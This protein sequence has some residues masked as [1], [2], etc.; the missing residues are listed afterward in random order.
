MN[1]KKNINILRL[2]L[3]LTHTSGVYH[4][5]ILPQKKISNQT[6]LSI[7][8]P[9]IKTK[10]AEFYNSD[11][12]IIRY[13]YLLKKILSEKDIDVI[14]AHTPHVGFL[15]I[16]FSIIFRKKSPKKLFS[17][18]YSYNFIKL[19]NQLSILPIF[20]F[21]DKIIFCSESSK[22]SFPKW[23]LY[24]ARNKSSIIYNG[25]DL[26]L[27]NEKN[28]K[29][30]DTSFTIITVSRLDKNKNLD[31]VIKAIHQL[32]NENVKLRIVGDGPEMKFLNKLSDSL[33]L[34]SQVIY[35]GQVKRKK[36]YEL[37][38]SSNLFISM[39]KTEGHP[40]SVLEA[41]G[42][43]KPV[44]LSNIGPH[45]EIA[46]DNNCVRITDEN[47]LV[48]SINHYRIKSINELSVISK[49]SKELI[50]NYFSIQ[51]MTNNYLTSYRKLL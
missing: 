38:S 1:N 9:E 17:I 24:F 42:A 23:I 32:K 2:I 15:F 16:V 14:H 37:L 51:K 35:Y 31:S 47:N 21:F 44:I 33:C 34:Q 26:E 11:N 50:K 18:H 28:I 7:F 30:D 3:N 6:I 49:S 25:V 20:L 10:D 13:L 29:P 5:T 22:N 45:L 36:V 39:S 48:K 12:S 40:V 46:K 19:R 43:G 4:Q 8:E 27:I 41:L